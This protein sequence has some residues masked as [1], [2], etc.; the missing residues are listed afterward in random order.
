V[1]FLGVLVIVG[2]AD[3]RLA[4]PLA[5]WVV[6]Y[7]IVLRYF[8]PRLGDVAEAQADARSLMTGRIVDSYT[9]IQTVKLFSHASREADYA[10]EGMSDFMVTAY[11]QGRLIT[12]LYTVIYAMNALLL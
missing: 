5:V 10:R 9:N 2:S 8:I 12:S 11:R 7:G 6:G 4:S 1:Y 3:W